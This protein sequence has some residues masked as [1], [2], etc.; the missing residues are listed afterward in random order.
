MRTNV[1]VGAVIKRGDKVLLIH[2]FKMGDEY[3][4]L[5][6]GGVEDGE[7]LE[8]AL[9]R[10]VLEETGLECI[11]FEKI[12]K[13]DGDKETIHEFF[14]VVL[15]ELDMTIGGPEAAD[16]SP[17]NQYILTWVNVGEVSALPSLF[18]KEVLA[19]LD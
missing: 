14:N 15:P 6:G 1:R 5:P 4:V 11:S 9:K 12:G 17:D 18:P 10:E 8:T 16:S 7:D 3:W 13:A 2:R 19:F